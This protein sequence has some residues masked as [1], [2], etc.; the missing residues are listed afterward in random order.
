MSE[1]AQSELRCVSQ[2]KSTF[3]SVSTKCPASHPYPVDS[4]KSCCASDEGAN[5]CQGRKLKADDAL[6]CC[7]DEQHLPCSDPPCGANYNAFER[8][9]TR[10]LVHYVNLLL[11]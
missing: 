3:I 1:A 4:Y 11:E 8:A 10:V 9:G 7:K 6:D 2:I 5:G